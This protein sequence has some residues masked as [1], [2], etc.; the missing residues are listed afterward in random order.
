MNDLMFLIKKNNPYMVVIALNPQVIC[1]QER[2]ST[3]FSMH[4]LANFS[5]KGSNNKT[6]ECCLEENGTKCRDFLP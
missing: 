4:L 1:E 5:L 3:L 6:T 2:H